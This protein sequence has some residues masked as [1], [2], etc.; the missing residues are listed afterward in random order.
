MLKMRLGKR[1]IETSKTNKFAMAGILIILTERIDFLHG[2]FIISG[3]AKSSGFYWMA[4]V[5]T[6]LCCLAA[7]SLSLKQ[8]M[9]LFVFLSICFMIHHAVWLTMSETVSSCTIPIY[10][11]FPFFFIGIQK[12]ISEF[13]IWFILVHF[14][15]WSTAFMFFHVTA[16]T[17]IAMKK[18]YL[19][20]VKY[21]DK[22]K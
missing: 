10:R 17:T 2:A 7:L 15:A 11:I 22:I 5:L 6:I 3:S 21:I 12:Y 14:F 16:L 1:C 13:N 19:R 20:I 4:A 8:R 9:R 18:I